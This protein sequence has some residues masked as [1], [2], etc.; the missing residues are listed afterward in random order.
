MG[1]GM[2]SSISPPEWLVSKTMWQASCSD[3]AKA[4]TS[5]RVQTS[6][7]K[8]VGRGLLDDVS[9]SELALSINPRALAPGLLAAPVLGPNFSMVAL[10]IGQAARP[11]STSQLRAFVGLRFHTWPI[12][13]VV[14]EGSLE[15]CGWDTWS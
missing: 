9:P 2:A 6:S 10:E 15:P 14:Y 13:L 3:H 8:G 1:S 7:S 11:I 4:W 5:G 12:N